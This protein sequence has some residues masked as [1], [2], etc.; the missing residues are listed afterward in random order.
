M[1]P[2][3]LLHKSKIKRPKLPERFCF[4]HPHKDADAAAAYITPSTLVPLLLPLEC[5]PGYVYQ[6]TS[7]LSPPCPWGVQSN[8]T[9]FLLVLNVVWF[10]Q[11]LR[12]I[13]RFYVSKGQ[14][15]LTCKTSSIS[16]E[17]IQ[18]GTG[19][20]VDAVRNHIRTGA[21]E[22]RNPSSS[23]HPSRQSISMNCAHLCADGLILKRHIGPA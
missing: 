13:D 1:G 20:N 16:V 23:C 10:I 21:I 11:A 9:Q 12:L 14:A 17:Q 8:Q 3:P 19:L 6:P 18:A 4:P 5:R 15:K 2:P 7:P 22:Y